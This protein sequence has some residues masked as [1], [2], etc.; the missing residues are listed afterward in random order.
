M[1]A[2][3]VR[4]RRKDRSRPWAAPTACF[5]RSGEA[6][7]QMAQAGYLCRIKLG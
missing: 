7:T 6:G 4:S 5:R 1:A 3:D 2:I